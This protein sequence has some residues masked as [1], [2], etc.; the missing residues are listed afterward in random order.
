MSMLVRRTTYVLLFTFLCIFSGCASLLGPR[1]IELPLARLQQTIDKKFPFNSHYFEL[2]DVT[3]SSP[4]LALVPDSNR[5]ITALDVRIAPTFI[6][7]PWQGQLII[8]GGLKID[9]AGNAVLLT[10]PRL[11]KLAINAATA[12]Q[13]DKLTKLAKLLAEDLFNNMVVYTFKPA[14]L[15][16]LGITWMPTK[17]TTKANSL[18]VSFEPKK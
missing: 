10:E 16:A 4:K 1:D 9:P 3:L 6:K 7:T 11:D 14:D 15:K 17:I 13:N 5:V 18:V 8:S 12:S 2:L